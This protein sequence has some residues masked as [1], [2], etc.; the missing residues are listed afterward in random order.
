MPKRHFYRISRLALLV[1][2]IGLAA[3]SQSHEIV[4]PAETDDV[5]NPTIE[6]VFL[7]LND[8]YEITPVEGGKTGGLARVATVRDSLLGLYPNTFTVLAG[9]FLSPSAL[10]TAKVDGE[11]IA[12]R[13]MVEVMNALGVDLVTF[14][15]HEF[16]LNEDRLKARI[17]ESQFTYV[18]GNVSEA[19]GEPFPGAVRYKILRAAKPG[20]GVLRIGILGVTGDMNPVDYVSY[21]N[22]VDTIKEQ[23]SQLQDSVDAFVALTHLFLA[24]DIG[25]ANAAPGL[26]LIMGGHEHENVLLLRGDGM[27]PI[28]K[29]DANAR[30]VYIHKLRYNPTTGETAVESTILPITEAIAGQAETESVVRSWLDRAWDGFRSS[31]FQP[32]EPVAV[33]SVPLDGRESVVLHQAT[34][35]TRV[36]GDG[37]RAAAGDVDVVVYNSGAIRIDDV[38][39]P[40]QVTQYDIIRVLPFGGSILTVEMR[41]S[42]LDSVLTQG[43]A[44][45]GSGGYLQIQGAA[46]TGGIWFI[47]GNA[48]LPNQTYRVALNDFLVSGYEA[49]LD[50]LTLDNPGVQKISDHGDMRF[51][52][53]EELRRRFPAR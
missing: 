19:D 37:I 39:T 20:V 46:E 3:C 33:V 27:V 16:D 13:H 42:L 9:D 12:G 52:V 36:I 34:E 48:V 25:L 17:A 11:R 23:M 45:E 28:A 8:V 50:Y 30:S 35:L 40:G 6:V 24:Q 18:A 22:Y 41:G 49:N 44:N 1:S 14:G 31:G 15:N 21:A 10:G 47:D 38:I 32:E 5:T 4:E 7:Q 26:D 51:A 43:M 29:A 53:I 2:S